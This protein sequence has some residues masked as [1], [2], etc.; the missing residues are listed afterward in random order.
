MTNQQIIDRLNRESTILSRQLYVCITVTVLVFGGAIFAA[1]YTNNN[2]I[3]AVILLWYESAIF[4]VLAYNSVSS[5]LVNIMWWR[6]LNFVV[7]FAEAVWTTVLL[8]RV[9]SEE[10]HFIPLSCVQAFLIISEALLSF[11]EYVHHALSKKEE[12]I[13]KLKNPRNDIQMVDGDNTWDGK[14]NA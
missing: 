10:D 12:D 5:T 8:S 9:E 14:M 6:F 4:F 3:G 7:L 1:L 13:N 11:Y 2:F